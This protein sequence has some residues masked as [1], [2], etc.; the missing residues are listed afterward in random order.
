[1]SQ[2]AGVASGEPVI[3]SAVS[4]ALSSGAE[5]INEFQGKRA[6]ISITVPPFQKVRVVLMDRFVLDA[7]EKPVPVKERTK[8][9]TDIENL[10]YK[11]RPK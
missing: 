11:P 1:V 6:D 3:G 7:E 8:W 4:G 10:E 9:E 2:V 5:Q